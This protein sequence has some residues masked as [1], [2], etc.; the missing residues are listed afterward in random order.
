MRSFLKE[1]GNIENQGSWIFLPQKIT[2]SFSNDGINFS[3][4]HIIYEGEVKENYETEIKKFEK[5]FKNIR[6]RY[7]HF[8]ADNVGTCPPYH[9]GSGAPAFIFID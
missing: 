2:V 9:K 3:E 6:S 7:I 4:P 1:I 5:E 8:V